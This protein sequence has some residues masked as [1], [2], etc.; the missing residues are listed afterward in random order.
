[1]SFEGIYKESLSK[2]VQQP[3]KD[4]SSSKHEAEIQNQETITI[5]RYI[6]KCLIGKMPENLIVDMQTSNMLRQEKSILHYRQHDSQYFNW[7]NKVAR[8]N[9]E[10]VDWIF[11]HSFRDNICLVLCIVKW[12]RKG[13][14]EKTKFIQWMTERKV[15]Q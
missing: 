1:M 10:Y 3:D 9:P 13:K 2:K 7:M 11:T 15:Y 4:N 12:E 5:N 14:L 8:R 6:Q